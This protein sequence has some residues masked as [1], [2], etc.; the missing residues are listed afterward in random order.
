MKPRLLLLRSL[1][2]GV[3]VRGFVS[4]ICFDRF[5]CSSF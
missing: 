2:A 4:A 3:G 1:L 5:V